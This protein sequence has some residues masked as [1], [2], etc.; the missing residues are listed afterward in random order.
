VSL[1][2]YYFWGNREDLEGAPNSKG[3]SFENG[4]DFEGIRDFFRGNASSITDV[5]YFET[6]TGIDYTASEIIFK[7]DK[8]SPSLTPS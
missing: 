7:K 4:D 5:V 2:A 3:G 6:Y 8:L 1:F